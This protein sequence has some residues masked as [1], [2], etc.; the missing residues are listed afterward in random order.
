[1]K[2]SVFG[3]GRLGLVTAACFATRG[4]TVF[5]IDTDL[6][7]TRSARNGEPLFF[8]PNLKRYLTR[9][10]RKG[11]LTVIQD[12]SLSPGSDLA[13]ITVGSPAQKDGSINLTYLKQAAK[14]IGRSLRTANAYQL[15]VVRSTVTPGTT[16]NVVKPIL[17]KESAKEAGRQFGLCSNPEFL[18]EGNAINDILHPDRII[19]GSE[20]AED[21]KR[22]G[23]FYKRFYRNNSPPILATTHENA[24]LIKYASNAFLATKVS[25]VN[26]IANIAERIP[27]AD[28]SVVA[29]GIGMDPRIGSQ[30]LKAG[31]GWSG[32]CLPKDVS[33]LQ[34][35]SSTLG[36]KAELIEATAKTNHMQFR[37]AVQ[38]A[39]SA[40][41]SLRGKRVA[42]L[43]LAFKPNTDD[44]RSAISIQVVRALLKQR[45]R[46]VAYDPAAMESTRTLFKNRIEYASDAIDCIRG[47]DCAI[48]VTEWNEFKSILPH[49]FI[50]QMRHPIVIDGRRIYDPE[51]FTQTGVRFLAIGLG[52]VRAGGQL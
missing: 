11:F 37:R 25:F 47:A 9:A 38:F 27:G 43:G 52:P 44:V 10:I 14:T 51:R 28:V 3:L 48:I 7:R 23:T 50:K 12:D 1:M 26:C 21:A 2:I 18:R 4:H 49:I 36:Y 13:M 19:I 8:E 45:A 42:V 34:R 39:K 32:S 40:L 15:V 17:E 46:I 33:A 29:S 31:L 6:R 30:Y 35:F 20:F 22:L 24:E 16:R 41:V 5:G